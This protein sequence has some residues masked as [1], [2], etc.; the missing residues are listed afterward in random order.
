MVADEA[1][2]LLL[3]SPSPPPG[4]LGLLRLLGLLELLELLLLV[5]SVLLL[6]MLDWDGRGACGGSAAGGSWDEEDDDRWE[7]WGGWTVV[8]GPTT[9]GGAPTTPGDEVAGCFRGLDCRWDLFFS[10]W[11]PSSS[12]DNMWRFGM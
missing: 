5:L 2:L 4:L 8:G 6:G 12:S 9:A 3:L 1:Q 7:A 11:L 10:K